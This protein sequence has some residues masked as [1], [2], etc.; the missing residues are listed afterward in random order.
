MRSRP[1]ILKLQSVLLWYLITYYSR[2]TGLLLQREK[3]IC[4]TNEIVQRRKMYSNTK[5]IDIRELFK[6]IL[7]KI[8]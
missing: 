3:I 7:L 1:F 5:K 8:Q 4:L 2:G 6:N